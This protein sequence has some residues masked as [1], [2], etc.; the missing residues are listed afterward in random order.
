MYVQSGMATRF[1]TARVSLT[2]LPPASRS[3]ALSVVTALNEAG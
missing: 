2:L 1:V 3:L